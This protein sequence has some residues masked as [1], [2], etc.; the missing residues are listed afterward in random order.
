MK[1]IGIYERKKIGCRDIILVMII[2]GTIEIGAASGSQV[3]L[4]GI[5][6]S[7]STVCP[8]NFACIFNFLFDKIEKFIYN[9]KVE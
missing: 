5:H 8:Y 2:L 3:Y 1:R 4:Y 6:D 7:S 9:N